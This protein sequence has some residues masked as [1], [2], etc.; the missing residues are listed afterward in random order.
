MKRS[1]HIWLIFAVCL[2]VVLAAMGWVTAVGLRLE[3]ERAEVQRVANREEKLRLALWRMDSALAS[4]YARENSRPYFAYSGF[5]PANRA[6]TRMFS[7]IEAGEVL[8]PSPLL[9]LDSERILLHFQIGPNGEITSPQA[10]SGNQ[11]D[12]AESRFVNP[13]K[14]GAAV[15]QLEELRG[16]IQRKKLL[17]SLE[18]KTKPEGK[19]EDLPGPVAAGGQREAL[20]TQQVMN[21]AEQQARMQVVKK[22][23]P[24]PQNSA[25]TTENI[26]EGPL[27][28]LWVKDTLLLARRVR[29]N[30]NLY[31]QGCWLNWEKLQNWLTDLV[32]DLLP[33]VHLEPVINQEDTDGQ[34]LASLPVRLVP[35]NVPPIPQNALSPVRISLGVAWICVLLATIAAILLLRGVLS[36]SERRA[37][38]VSAVTHELRTPLTTFQMY[39]EMLADG[40]VEEPEKRDRY[41]ETLRS[42]AYRLQHLVENV[43][44]F[45]RLERGRSRRELK[46]L[47]LRELTERAC[48]RLQDHVERTGNELKCTVDAAAQDTFVKVDFSAIEHILFNLV[49]NACKYADRTDRPIKLTAEREQDSP[50]IAVRDYGPGI[51]LEE[52]KSVFKPFRKSARQAADSAPG[53]GL[54]LALSRRLAREMGGDLKL[55]ETDGPGACFVLRLPPT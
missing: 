8:I 31:V 45:A 37:A 17:A 44:A 2:A 53:V 7:K 26:R 33:D 27:H 11:R 6:Y 48:E 39:S 43:L 34:R 4:L 40:M 18:E 9:T 24:A 51:P 28:P 41:L 29:V 35:G 21:V 19:T 16:H 30:E 47:N 54:G 15:A 1:W 55:R 13:E 50:V 49:D 20:Q 38:F 5:Y 46:E 36:L 12:L 10:P 25:V 3:K 23:A 14:I 22:N 32:K 42:Q 52:A